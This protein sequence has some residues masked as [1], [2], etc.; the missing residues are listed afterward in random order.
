M[1]NK[2]RKKAN[3]V[4]K[5]PDSFYIVSIGA[6]AGGL[7][8]FEKFFKNMP[9]DSD[10]AFV[11]VPHLDPTHA[12]LMPELIQKCSKMEVI[13]IKDGTSVRPN[14]IYIVPPN[15]NLAILKRTLQLLAPSKT[16]VP[17]MPIDYFFRSLAE[18]QGDKAIC[19]ILSGM[20]SDG[21]IGL[22]AIKGELGMAMVQALESAKYDSMP[23]SAIETRLV[24]YILPPE[25]M[26]EQLIAY[27]KLS[28]DKVKSKLM[29]V[30]GKPTDELQKIFILLRSRTGHD[31]S[32]YKPNTICRRIERRMNVQQIGK[33]STY[34]RYLQE[35]SGEIDILFKELLIGVTNFFRDR[36]GFEI[37]KTKALPRILQDKPQDY[38]VRVWI[39][40]CSTGEEA[41]ST[42]IILRECTEQLKQHYG[43]QI[44]ATD[45]DKDSIET[46]RAGTYAANIIADVE[47]ERLG[48]F[49]NEEGNMYLVKKDIRE[50]LV[51]APQNIIK[52]PPFTK[53]DLIC[54][55]NLLIYLDSEIQ[56]KM[57][58]LFHYSLKPGGLLF[59]GSSET[60]GS[61]TDLFAPIDKKW[62]IFQRKE[63]VSSHQMLAGF[64]APSPIESNSHARDLEKLEINVA[65]MAE[66]S[67]LSHYA[68]PCV[69]I[70][71]KGDILYIHGRTG[72]YLEPSPGEARLNI[73]EMAREG[74][75]FELPAAIRKVVTY[76]KEVVYKDLKVLTNGGHQ[77]VKLVIKPIDDSDCETGL[78]LVAFEEVSPVPAEE[79]GKRKRASKKKVDEKVEALEKELQYSKESLQT[80]IEEL[81]TSNEELKST[82]EELQSTN[83]ELQSTNEELETSKEEQ[84]SLNEEL[85]TVNSELQGKI[86]ELTL[87]NNDMK[88][89]LDSLEVPTIF[90]DND[91][92]IKRF[93]SHATRVIKIIPTDIGRPLDDIV[94]K[95][96][97]EDLMP[98]VKAV[99]ADLSYR[100]S[101]VET[102][103]GKRYLMRILPYRTMENVIDGVTITFLDITK[104]KLA[105]EATRD[106]LVMAESIV[107]SVREPLIILD[108]NLK[109]Q[110]ANK[111]FYRTF[112]VIPKET[113]HHNIYD[114]GNG[115]WDIPKLRELLGNIIPDNA[116]FDN[117]VVEHEFPNIG[118]KK[119]ILNARRIEQQGRRDSLILLGIEIINDRK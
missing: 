94:M 47:Q 52:D 55:R 9:D 12:S 31:F 53:L 80:T 13:Q 104:L 109:V 37:L 98:D 78:I 25:S 89:L 91:I 51:F 85:T 59:L 113:I 14:A 46:A 72:K 26:P 30:E 45:I 43:L 82:N 111:T 93:T 61:F 116:T 71:E 79:T 3:T 106:A 76:K 4:P 65:Q 77:T 67:L 29:P 110:T 119:M 92:R 35:N 117:F 58:P 62:K 40:G 112:Q 87:A 118:I 102:D 48:R 56:K 5:T 38:I 10:M 73:Y 57:L 103:E 44:F 20:G 97:Y 68:P 7:E 36:E 105:E 115:Q 6:S 15:K 95:L 2:R 39:P 54:C 22:R 33:I 63:G 34:V 50:L 83:E 60:I 21:T 90:L 114:L 32:S 64:S 41:Y 100:E 28:V 42:A 99:L 23:R 84:Q 17:R 88:N 81:E 1:M 107:E 24:D 18:D 11:L 108:G 19:V 27:A 86:E 16:K 74:L 8:A 66:K 49:F 101:E 96:K 70:N 75:K 69:I